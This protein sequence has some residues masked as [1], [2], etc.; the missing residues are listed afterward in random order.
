MLRCNQVVGSVATL[1]AT[2]QLAIQPRTWSPV[3]RGVFSRQVLFT[4][5]DAI[6]AALRFSAAVGL[7]LIVQAAMWVDMLGVPSEIVSP[8]LWRSIVREIAPLLAC[9]VVI[10]RS[11]IAISTELASMRVGGEFEILDSQGVDP[12][13]YLVMPRVLAVTISVFFL[14]V[15]VA[16][17]MVVTGYAVGAVMGVIRIAWKDFFWEISSHFVLQDLIFFGSKTLL[18]GGF[19][20][21]ICCLEGV[22]IRGAVTDIPRV[23]SRAGIRAMTSVFVVSAVLSIL[24]YQRFL[25]FKFE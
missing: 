15:I 7:L 10:G 4:A 3:V 2:F 14:A 17:T 23:A 22:S 25:I 21:V 5:V 18:A 19:V 8:I 9:L 13:T 12:M 6:P 16:V 1:G 20:G 24:F 11:G